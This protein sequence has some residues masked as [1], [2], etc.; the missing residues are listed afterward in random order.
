MCY[1]VLMPPT[2]NQITVYL[3]EILFQMQDKD[4]IY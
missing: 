2:Q 3:V 1:K 4:K